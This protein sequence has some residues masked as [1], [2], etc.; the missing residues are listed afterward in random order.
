V[1]A[2][3]LAKSYSFFPLTHKL[4]WQ[5]TG[6]KD[7]KL[8][9]PFAPAFLSLSALGSATRLARSDFPSKTDLARPSIWIQNTLKS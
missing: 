6:A 1:P 8:K 2:H 3:Y 4:R 5:F 7:S 9:L